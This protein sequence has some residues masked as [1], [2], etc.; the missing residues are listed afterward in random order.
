MKVW[1]GEGVKQCVACLLLVITEGVCSSSHELNEYKCDCCLFPSPPPPPYP[2]LPFPTP[3]YQ[4]LRSH[5]E[6]VHVDPKYHPKII[7]KK[8][9]MINKI[10]KDFGVQI[11]FPEKEGEGGEDDDVI[12][13]TGYE[14]QTKSARDAILKVVE[15]LVCWLPWQPFKFQFHFMFYG[16]CILLPYIHILFCHTTYTYL[17]TR[18]CCAYCDSHMHIM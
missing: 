4:E 7:G 9:A 3:P 11:Q 16:K 13:I 15:E 6:V 8:G 14:H 17:H 18:L 5:K 12:E 1:W 2:S 10:R